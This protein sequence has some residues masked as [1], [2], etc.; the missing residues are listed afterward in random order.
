MT[1]VKILIEGF[2]NA[3]SQS[4]GGE[5]KTSPTI[6]LI[7]D[8][9]LNIIVDPGV[10]ESQQVLIDR[11]GEE[12]LTVNDIDIVF[13]T[14]SH[15]DHYRNIGMFPNAKTLEY[16]GLWTGQ[17]C[18]EYQEQFT[19]GIKVIKTP[20]HSYDAL[21]FLV[22]TEKGVV[23]I[24]GDV[25]WRENS[26]ENDPYASDAGKLKESRKKVLEL[27]DYIIPGHGPMYKVE[28]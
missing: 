26:P 1:K 7:K 27:A 23:V 25:F 2:T 3:D 17:R 9:D 18:D 22:E 28:K 12:G 20:G 13:L 14:H 19:E 4:S 15:I 21:S 11:L 8:K 24:V 5:E 6:T 16:F 10:L